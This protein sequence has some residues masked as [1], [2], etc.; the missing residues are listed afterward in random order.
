MG[1]RTQGIPGHSAISPA[2]AQSPRGTEAAFLF[3]FAHPGA[4]FSVGL[5]C[6]GQPALAAGG[7]LPAPVRVRGTGLPWS[8]CFGHR[9]IPLCPHAGAQ[10]VAFQVS[11][12]GIPAAPRR[13]FG[14]CFGRWRSLPAPALP[15]GLSGVPAALWRRL[16]THPGADFGCQGSLPAP[17][18]ARRTGLPRSASF[19]RQGMLPHSRTCAWDGAFLVSLPGVS[20]SLCGFP[21]GHRGISPAP[22]QAL[23][24]TPSAGRASP[25]LCPPSHCRVPTCPCTRVL[26]FPA[27]HTRCP[28]RAELAPAHS[29]RLLRLLISC[30]SSRCP[31]T[32]RYKYIYKY[33]T[34]T[35]VG[36]F[37]GASM[38]LAPCD[39]AAILRASWVPPF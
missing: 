2:P 18:H 34:R 5:G 14:A 22:K 39:A 38:L 7:F 33:H 28:H 8:A 32:T 10:H 15:V 4:R 9:G 13:C 24:G 25:G 21:C 26:G 1:R 3:T 36:P 16:R 31:S 23:D 37:P 27:R 35:I 19:G 17:V 29:L 12:P 20:G 11:L 30:F 6:P